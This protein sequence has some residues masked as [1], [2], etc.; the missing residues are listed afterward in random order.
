MSR[1]G[2][3]DFCSCKIC[4]FTIH[5][6]RITQGGRDAGAYMLRKAGDRGT[7]FRSYGVVF[8][9]AES[10]SAMRLLAG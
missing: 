3:T 10:C 1:D 5:G 8:V 6:G 2:R 4:T 9:G 7:R